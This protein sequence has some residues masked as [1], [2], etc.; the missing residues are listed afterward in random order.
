MNASCNMLD[1]IVNDQ[2]LDNRWTGVVGIFL[3]SMFYI[4]RKK[5][6]CQHLKL[7]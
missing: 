2:K 3:N 6:N 4:S 7:L 1:D 5:I